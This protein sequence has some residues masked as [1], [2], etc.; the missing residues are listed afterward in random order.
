MFSD[1]VTNLDVVVKLK[2]GTNFKD[3]NFLYNDIK[4]K[5]SHLNDA[6]DKIVKEFCAK[7]CYNTNK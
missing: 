5:L 4:S 7:Y 2:A 1:L 6:N 3:H